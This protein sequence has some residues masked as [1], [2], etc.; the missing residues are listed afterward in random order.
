MLQVKYT[1]ILLSL[2]SLT[3]TMTVVQ[4]QPKQETIDYEALRQEGR[5]VWEKLEKKWGWEKIRANLEIFSHRL[6]SPDEQAY[7]QKAL[8][9]A[10]N[11]KNDWIKRENIVRVLGIMGHAS[12]IEGLKE[13]A[14]QASPSRK[15]PQSGVSVWAVISLSFIADK[16]VIDVLIE[17]VGHPNRLVRLEALTRLYRLVGR[18][19]LEN[20]N[21]V[22][23]LIS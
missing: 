13:I 10:K 22:K 2:I 3:I 6:L 17:L 9:F 23:G 20:I 15:D 21:E 4:E 14:W 18:E 5:K 16:Q 12:M 1:W 11:L 7:I 19:M 8:V